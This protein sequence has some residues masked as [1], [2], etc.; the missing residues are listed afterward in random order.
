[1]FL[2][3]IIFM[4]S[5]NIL[6]INSK[7]GIIVLRTVSSYF[8]FMVTVTHIYIT[9]AFTFNPGNGGGRYV[10]VSNSISLQGRLLHIFVFFIMS[11][12]KAIFHDLAHDLGYTSWSS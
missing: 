8:A 12:S 7:F 11:Q 10:R 2:S 9:K 3:K 4:I 5:L 6:K 1:M